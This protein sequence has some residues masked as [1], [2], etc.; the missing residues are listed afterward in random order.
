MAGQWGRNDQYVEPHRPPVNPRPDYAR[1]QAYQQQRD[2]ARRAGYGAESYADPNR[3]QRPPGPMRQRNGW[4]IARRIIAVLLVLSVVGAVVLWF[5]LDSSFH[6]VNALSDYSGRPAQGTGTNWLI[7]GSDSR[8]GLTDA[9]AAQLHTGNASDVSGGRTDTIILLHL[10]DN[11]TKPTMVSLLRDSYV[12]IPGHGKNKINAAYA[13]GGPSLLVQTVELATGLRVDHYAEIGLGGFAS[14]VDDVGGVTMCLDQPVNDSYAG[15]NLPAGCQNLN[16]A[17]ALGYVRSRHAFATSDFA[18]TDH[19]RQFLGA[20]ANKISSPG[21]LLNPFDFFPMVSDLP[22]AITVDNGD[23][24]Q[25]LLGLGWAMRGISSGGVISTAV[26]VSGSTGSSLL[27]DP[28]KSQA[29][30][31]DLNTDQ[32]VPSTLITNH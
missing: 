9:Q 7:V 31:Q 17:N 6:R 5:Y 19:Q 3:R 32:A 2:Q 13:F 18:R 12:N 25:N 24:L 21:T 1:Q 22:T 11:S 30:F 10:P 15:I 28:T 20:L 23:H 27:W 29:L 8:Q 4:R 26:P 16:G 14:V